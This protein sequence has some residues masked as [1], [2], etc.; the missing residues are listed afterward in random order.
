MAPEE[1]AFS[2][3]DGLRIAADLVLPRDE[4]KA[5]VVMCPGF[6]GG[7]RGGAALSVADRLAGEL[8]WAALLVDYSGFGGSEGPPGR[9]DPERQV[10]DVLAAVAYLRVR[11]DG[12]P[13]TIFGNSFGAGIAAVATARD[14]SVACLFS[15]C[16]FSSGRALTAENRPWWGRIEWRESLERDRLERVVSGASRQVDP[17]TVIVRDR[18]AERYMARLLAT[19]Q[20]R[21]SLMALSDAQRLVDFEPIAEAPRLRG[22]RVLFVHCERDNFIP[23]WHSRAMAE[24][25]AAPCRL[26]PYGHYEVYDGEPREVLLRTA[27]DF[28]RAALS[29]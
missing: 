16:A 26:L 9:F 12:R 29:C 18:E 10:H 14:A 21:K 11:F 27:V 4:P 23:A 15:L 1:V 19:G 5:A 25:A 6:R 22:R 17:D 13:V 8:G 7:R 2:Q 20:A 3:D 28:Y 24:A